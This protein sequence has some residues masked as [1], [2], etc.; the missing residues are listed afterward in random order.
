MFIVHYKGRGEGCDYTIGCNQITVVLP[1]VV[2]TMDDAVAYVS[3]GW[4]PE[5]ADRHSVKYFGGPKRIEKATI[6]EVANVHE[7]DI[8]SMIVAARERKA[9]K[10]RKLEEAEFE[11]LKA[12]LGK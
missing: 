4:K 8:Q 12:K 6:Y 2:Q 10:A 5:V 7:L 3:G 9:A 11:R 1:D